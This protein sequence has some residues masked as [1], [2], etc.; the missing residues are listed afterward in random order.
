[1]FGQRFPFLPDCLRL[2]AKRLRNFIEGKS[3]VVIKDGKILEENL[4]K[5]KYSVDELLQLFRKKDAFQVADVE[6]GML[7]ANGELNVLLK[8]EK[9]P[10]TA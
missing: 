3:T 10:I 7:E 2:K 6:F 4:T 1:M 5:E 9:Q 8:K